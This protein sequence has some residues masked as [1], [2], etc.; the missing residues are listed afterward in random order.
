MGLAFAVAQRSEDPSIKHGCVLVSKKHNI[1]LGTGYN[2]LIPGLTPD[3]VDI[4]TR[5]RKY[6][7][8]RHAEEN[9]LKN[10]SQPI[11]FVEGGVKA[12]V[13]GKPCSTK[14]GCLQLLVSCGI[15]DIYVAKRRGFLV[16]NEEI[17]RDFDLIVAKMG[18]NV[19]VIE[20]EDIK[21]LN[22][23]VLE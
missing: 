7:W 4:I 5:P 22:E 20:L 13:T 12:Y 9:A 8:M 3:D 17:Q 19:T 15:K 21:W 14:P 23:I 11:Q 1:I 16:H 2:G 6:D 18:I 10:T